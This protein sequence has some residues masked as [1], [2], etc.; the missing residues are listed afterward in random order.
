[1]TSKGIK[2][3]YIS[4]YKLDGFNAKKHICQFSKTSVMNNIIGSDKKGQT[5]I[6]SQNKARV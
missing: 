1:M 2:D 4:Q 5:K 3:I 6:D